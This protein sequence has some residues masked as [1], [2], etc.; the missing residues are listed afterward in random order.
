MTPDRPTGPPVTLILPRPRPPRTELQGRYGTLVPTAP[1]HADALHAAFARD[2]A[3]HGWT[4]LPYGPF[5][6]A[7]AF[8]DW[9]TRVCLGDDPLF[10]TI[11]DPEGTPLGLASYLRIDPAMAV[12]EVGHIHLSPAL[13]RTALATEAMALMMARAFDELGYRRYEWKCDALNAPSRRAAQR[14]GFTYE[15]TFRQAAVVK[16]RNRDTAW[17]SILDREW[18]AQKARFDRWLAPS[19]FDAA[20]RQ[21]QPLSPEV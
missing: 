5:P 13:Q 2:G 20:G 4:Y 16:G 6:D 8:A 14:L 11:C 10:H 21:R 19:N 18:P 7:G 1:D 3:G 12:I 9:L 17:F 15:G